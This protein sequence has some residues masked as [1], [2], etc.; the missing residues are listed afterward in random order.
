M[1]EGGVEN[2]EKM[3]TSFM[4]GPLLTYLLRLS[5]VG[6]FTFFISSSFSTLTSNYVLYVQKCN[7]Y[8]ML[9]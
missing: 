9:S 6:S 8:F 5:T 1:G 7:S 2:L 3:P 4:D